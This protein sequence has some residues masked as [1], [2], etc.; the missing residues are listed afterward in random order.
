MSDVK[1]IL[2]IRDLKTGNFIHQL[3]L[4]I[5]SVSEI[6]CRREDKEVFIGF[7]SFLSPSIIYWCNLASTVP[8]MKVFREISVPGFDRTSFQVN[9]VGSLPVQICCTL[10]FGNF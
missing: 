9:Q 8:E 6:S 7:T 2:Q 3:P 1:H 5:G 4:E 10:Y